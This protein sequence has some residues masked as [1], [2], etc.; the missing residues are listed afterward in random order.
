MIIFDLE[1]RNHYRLS[2]IDHFLD[3]PHTNAFYQDSSIF[4]DPFY[5][6]FII[7]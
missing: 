6:I 1:I 4:H 3:L 2:L 5:D 7:I